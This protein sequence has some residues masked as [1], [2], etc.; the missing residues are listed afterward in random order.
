MEIYFQGKNL[1]LC[2]RNDG[3]FGFSRFFTET[4][5]NFTNY[6]VMERWKNVKTNNYDTFVL[7]I[8]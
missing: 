6:K 5:K 2:Y 8:I 4:Y 7:S 1:K 3:T